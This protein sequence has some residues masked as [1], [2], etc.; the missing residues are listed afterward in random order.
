MKKYKVV[1]LEDNQIDAD[2]IKRYLT[3]STYEFEVRW[4]AKKSEFEVSLSEF[5]PDLIISDYNLRYYDAY[6]VLK[7]I[8]EYNPDL[9]V[10]IISGTIGEEEAVNLIKE[11]AIDFLIKNNLV[12]L[13]QIA[14]RALEET[15]EKKERE[16]AELALRKEKFFTDKLLDSM[17]GLFYLLDENLIIKR[18]NQSFLSLLGYSLEE[19]IGQPVKKFIAEEDLELLDEIIEKIENS[20]EP[21]VE[22]RLID[23]GGRKLHYLFTGTFMEQGGDNY[24]I[25]TAIDISERI[26]AEVQVK[27]ALQEKEILLAEI[28]HRVKNNLAVVSGMMQLQAMEDDDKNVQEKLL[29]S[30]SRIKSI[31]MVHEQMYKSESFSSLRFDE[32]MDLLLENIQQISRSPELKVDSTISTDEINLNINQAIPCAIIVN[33]VVTNMYKHAFS[34]RKKGV[35]KIQAKEKS[36]KISLTFKDD[37]IGLPE[38]VLTSESSNLGFKL[39]DLLT[40]QL[41]G[42]LKVTSENG[43]TISLTFPKTSKK[44][45]G[46]S[47]FV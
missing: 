2:L 45:A 35:I 21:S 22:L 5:K 23:K 6:D 29:S 46:S 11:G 38:N 19:V 28:H 34:G 15:I 12:R 16:K 47:H 7:I 1:I 27:E 18:V 14:V 36:G 31:A 20:D 17:S 42:A 39:I 4:I 43:T 44:G 24:I 41:N 9:P 26:Q 8:H 33:E 10:V 13:P 25:G 3:R 30:V 37:G 32:S 40:K